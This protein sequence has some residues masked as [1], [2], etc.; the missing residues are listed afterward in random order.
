MHDSLHQRLENEKIEKLKMFKIVLER[1]ML[2]LRLNKQDIQLIH[3]D[4]LVSVEKN[5]SKFLSSNLARSKTSSSP[6]QG[7]LHQSS[8]QL[9][10]P[11]SLDG[12]SN[13]PMQPCTGFHG[14]NATELSHQL[15]TL[16]LVW[17]IDNIQFSTT[18]D[19]CGK[20]WFQMG[21]GTG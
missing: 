11:Q 21:F 12:Q 15:A 16:F 4:K 5:I 10:Q 8:K 7:Q 19:K 13:P 6:Q 17:R 2:F 9:Q 3:K 20:A 14:G 1:I 18:H